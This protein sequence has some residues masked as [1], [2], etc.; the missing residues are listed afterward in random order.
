MGKYWR[1]S[2]ALEVAEVEFLPG[3]AVRLR[4]DQITWPVRSLS[5]SRGKSLTMTPSGSV[6]Q[7]PNGVRVFTINA[8]NSKPVRK[9]CL[10]SQAPG[11][12]RVYYRDW[13]VPRMA[14]APR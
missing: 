13:D 1:Y 2:G 10:R 7:S 12:D 3:G 8:S 6:L 4:R 14:A 9:I 5:T 11:I